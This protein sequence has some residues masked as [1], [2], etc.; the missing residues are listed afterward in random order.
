M[1]VA[2]IDADFIGRKNHR[3]PNL[4]CMN[5]PIIEEKISLISKYLNLQRNR[6]KFYVLCGFDRTGKYNDAFWLQD[7]RDLLFRIDLLNRYDCLPYIMKFKQYQQ[8]HFRELYI[9]LA[10]WCNQP[11]I[12]KGMPFL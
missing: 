6:V 11:R 12:F 7:V 10:N 4:C 1:K 3:F 5:T 2:V 8:S 9:S